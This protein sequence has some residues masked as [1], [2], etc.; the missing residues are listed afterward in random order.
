MVN[1]SVVAALISVALT[2]WF[3]VLAADLARLAKVPALTQPVIRSTCY[4][5]SP[6]SF[7]SMFEK[8]VPGIASSPKTTANAT[9]VTSRPMII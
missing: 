6:S 4:G 5:F 1:G 3:F 8:G 9:T 7:T 2:A